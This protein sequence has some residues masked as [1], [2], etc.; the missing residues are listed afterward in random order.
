MKKRHGFLFSC[1]F[2]A[3]LFT[4]PATAQKTKVKVDGQ[5]I[6]NTVSYMA[7][8]QFLGRKPN[9]PEFDRI[10][11]WVVAQYKEWGLEPA[12]ENGAYF[13]SVPIARSYAVTYGT[14]ALVINGRAFFTRFEDFDIDS[15]STAGTTISGPIVFAGCGIS[16]PDK[17]L[18]EYAGLDVTGK[19]VLVFKGNPND[20][21]P[22]RG[23]M[24]A[25]EVPQEEKE[26][27][28]K[29]I[30][31]SMDD[32]K[33]MT[34]Y[35][36][37]AAGILLYNPSTETAGRFRGPGGELKASPFERA[38]IVVSQ[39]NED[40][41]KWILWT[42]SQQSAQSFQ[43]WINGIR[44]DIRKKTPRS[45]V[46]SAK[47]EV[48]GFEKVIMRGKS[49]GDDDCRNIIAK[50][51]GTDPKLKNE[52]VV[53]GGH[54]DHVGVTDGQIYNGA[55]DNAS[56]SAVVFELARLMKANK[57]KTKRT[58]IFCLWTAEELGLIGS[59]YW[60]EHPTDGVT[61]DKVATYFNMDMVGIGDK[62]GAPGALNFPEIWEVIKKNQ[63]PE[64][65]QAVEASE[66]GPGGSDHSAFIEQGIEAMALM[67]QGPGGHPDYHDTGDD[68]QKIDPKILGM[69]GQ[70]VL[71][72]TL[73]LANE[74]KVPLL[75]SQRK[76][77]YNAMRWSLSVI[78]P[79]LKSRGGWTVLEA[80]S[81]DDLM[82]MLLDKVKELKT[83]ADAEANPMAR[84]FRRFRP[85][86]NFSVGVPGAEI[87]DHDISLLYLAKEAL[88]FGRMDIKGD[89]GIWFKD[90]LTEKGAA[91]LAALQDSAIVL[92]LIHPS[93]QTLTAVLNAAKKP[94]LVSG[95][96]GL[97]D[98]MIKTMNEKDVLVAVA[99]D[100]TNVR[101]CVGELESLKKQ[102]GDAG[103][104]VLDIL[105]ET[106]IDA[107]KKE[108]YMTLLAK[109]WKNEEISAIGGGGGGRRGGYP[110][111]AGGSNFDKLAGPM[112][113]MRG[114]FGG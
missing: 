107:A 63:E 70:F 97:N 8:D 79:E 68:P 62:I 87:F 51:T 61:L 72:G 31:E 95:F 10:Q 65:I 103:N 58:V 90:G 50:I 108:L 37:G 76:D 105:S 83:P 9:T 91:A 86:T 1:L 14:P 5:K 73:N 98:E 49:F 60:A 57:I 59:R 64:V 100:P 110:G 41:M 74:T 55:E 81:K 4:L 30:K 114:D 28:E 22:Q 66:G 52:Y 54:F 25:P 40:V 21:V 27:E 111:G 102:F 85:R 67:T 34:A 6:F 35:D 13:Q 88:G 101:G 11:D 46:T 56:G 32:T 94:F 17:G 2:A 77:K 109:G 69:T 16:A 99:F 75:I 82:K 44:G 39:V 45:F 24:M 106:G 20:Y 7:S 71:Q 84:F 43:N 53:M 12:G 93:A 42:D 29:W 36:K 104:L 3:L 48:T 92:H 89:D 47:A 78:N 96:S 15:R 38:F 18:D 33:I 113:P 80:K 19:L 26:P 112:P 23:R